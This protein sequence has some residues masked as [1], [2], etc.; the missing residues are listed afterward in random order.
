[1]M[2]L[3]ITFIVLV[4]CTGCGRVSEAPYFYPT[5]DVVKAGVDSSYQP[6]T[7]S[8]YD[9]N[10]QMYESTYTESPKRI[11]A[12]WQN[13]IET[14]IAL[15]EGDRIV[16]GIGIPDVKYVRPEYRDAYNKIPY[17]SL[18]NLDLE[19]ILM[20]K[21]D[22]MVGWRSTFT[23][24]TLQTTEFWNR[25]G[26]HTYIAASSIGGKGKTQTIETEYQYI[27][28]LGK[29]FHKETVAEGLISDMEGM[30][31]TTIE[32]TQSEKEPR[33]A[34]IELQGKSLRLYGKRTLAGDIGARLHAEVMDTGNSL[35]SMEDLITMNPDVI[36]LIVSDGSYSEADMHMAYIRN[37]PSLQRLQAIRNGRIYFLPLLAVYSPGIRLSDGITI[38]SHGLY[39][40]LYPEG[41]PDY[42]H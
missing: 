8:S 28:D 22:L 1:M 12:V 31:N 25:R 14:L 9:E 6:V 26:V 19:T 10:G 33:V 39:P 4:F 30:I 23:P 36:F 7:I 27:R 35:I 11:I 3:I 16:A 29:I 34:F 37:Q 41:V 42:L 17:T 21:A 13:S 2:R 38:V 32:R 5:S 20:M 15:G 18:E 40:S 24:K